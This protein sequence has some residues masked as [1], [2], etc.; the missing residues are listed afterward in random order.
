M[1]FDMTKR[2]TTLTLYR[3][4]QGRWICESDNQALDGF[5]MLRW[6]YAAEAGWDFRRV[7]LE[8]ESC[9]LGCRVI[10]DVGK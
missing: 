3:D 8:V 4:A 1:R 5:P 2:T 6:G 10:Q 7:K 9:N